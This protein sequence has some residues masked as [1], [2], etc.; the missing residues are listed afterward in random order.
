MPE[1]CKLKVLPILVYVW[2]YVLTVCKTAASKEK[3]A[4]VANEHACLSLLHARRFALCRKMFWQ[5]VEARL[6]LRLAY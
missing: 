4:Q 6:P 1:L 5:S 3:N 2:S